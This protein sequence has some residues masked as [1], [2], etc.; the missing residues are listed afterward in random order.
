MFDF[1]VLPPEINSG[2]MYSG[3]GSASMMAAATAWDRLAAELDL[4]AAVYGS[5]VS[6]LTSSQWMGPASV[7]MVAAATPYVEWLSATARQAEQA[8]MQA[9]AAAAAY[10]LAFLMTVPPPVVAANRALLMALIATNFFGQNTPAIAATEAL[11]GEMWAQDAAAMYGYASA[12]LTAMELTPFTP[13]PTTTNPAAFAGQAATVGTAAIPAGAAALTVS[14]STAAAVPSAAPAIALPA[15]YWAFVDWMNAHLPALSPANRTTIVRL[16]GLSY[17]DEGILQSFVAMTQTLIPGS[18]SAGA[19]DSGSS[20]VDSWGSVFAGTRA[21]PVVG[22]GAR[23]GV[24]PPSSP[25]WWAH[26]RET[27][28]VTAGV[29]KGGSIGGLSVTPDWAARARMIN[30]TAWGRPVEQDITEIL[31]QPGENAI[32]RGIPM[33]GTSHAASGGGGFTHKY[34]FRYAVMQ[35]P[36]F[37]G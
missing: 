4:T 34:G 22:A 8:G 35:R 9:R 33:G 24:A 5:V 25:N 16:L 11:Y 36:P 13:A 31:K 6:E 3:P 2:R 21:G 12:S 7:A 18:P 29:G 1:G 37:A 30:P 27:L 19:G 14:S 23:V 32:L 26:T 15:W 17:F 20:V 28:G 10:E